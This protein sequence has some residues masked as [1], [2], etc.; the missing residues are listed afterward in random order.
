LRSLRV[1]ADLRQLFEERKTDRLPTA[2]IITAL[3]EMQERPWPEFNFGIASGSKRGGQETFKGYELKQFSEAFSR[4]LPEDPSQRHNPIATPRPEELPSV[5]K[6]NV[7]RIQKPLKP[8]S[9]KECDGVTDRNP[10]TTR[11]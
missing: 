11:I 10:W 9:D 5:T 7:C 1:L 6:G 3:T 4:Y 8:A 2:D